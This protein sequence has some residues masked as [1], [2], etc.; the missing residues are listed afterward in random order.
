MIW[1][2]DKPKDDGWYW[3]RA[4]KLD[5]EPDIVEIC[6]GTV[7]EC[8]NGEYIEHEDFSGE[9]SNTTIPEPCEE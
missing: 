8:R 6:D 7:C 5:T 4:S 2:T 9:W 1:I 3:W